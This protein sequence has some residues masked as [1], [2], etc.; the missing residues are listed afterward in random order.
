MRGTRSGWNSRY[1]VRQNDAAEFEVLDHCF[2]TTDA[3]GSPTT[4]EEVVGRFDTREQAQNQ[5]DTLTLLDKLEDE[6]FFCRRYSQDTA[7][8]IGVIKF[9]HNHICKFDG[10]NLRRVSEM[11]VLDLVNC[12]PDA[13]PEYGIRRLTTKE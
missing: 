7:T 1:E 12:Y 11:S 5:S 10:T 4:T 9:L 6:G 3:F 2:P 8:L 13:F